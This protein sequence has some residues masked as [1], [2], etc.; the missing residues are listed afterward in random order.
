MA[1]AHLT[2]FPP[3]NFPQ[4][5]PWPDLSLDQQAFEQAK[6]E[7]GEDAIVSDLLARAQQIKTQ[8]KEN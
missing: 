6:R 4:V 8:L 1:A 7:L 2:E 3:H 5:L